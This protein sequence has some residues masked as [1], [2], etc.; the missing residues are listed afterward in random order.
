MHAE[1]IIFSFYFSVKSVFL[2]YFASEETQALG[3]E[4][5]K[6]ASVC[7]MG[8][9]L[10]FFTNNCVWNRKALSSH[11]SIIYFNANLTELEQ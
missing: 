5:S 1:N 9:H 11:C 6:R 10:G 7:Q 8:T 4:E 2:T 3:D